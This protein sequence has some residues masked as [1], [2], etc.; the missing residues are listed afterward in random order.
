MKWQSLIILLAI[1]L[2]IVAPPSLPFLP[3]HGAMSSVG[4]PDV[5]HAAMPALSSHG[6]MPC[7]NERPSLL[8][9]LAQSNSVEVIIS[10]LKPLFIFFQDERPPQS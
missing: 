6:D 2:S 10:S 8:L 5:C 7:M 1:A 9:P 3:A 4:M